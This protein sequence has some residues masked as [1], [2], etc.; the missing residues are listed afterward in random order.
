MTEEKKTG[1]IAPILIVMLGLATLI[2]APYQLYQNWTNPE[3]RH[4]ADGTHDRQKREDAGYTDPVK[5]M[6]AKDPE[7]YRNFPESKIR[8][9]FCNI[10]DRRDPSYVK[11]CIR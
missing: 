2:W 7:L 11:T 6:I 5:E 9:A 10:L 4:Y 1:V 8:A 3:L